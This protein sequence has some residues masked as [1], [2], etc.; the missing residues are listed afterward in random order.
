MIAMWMS[1]GQ[2]C[3]P[4]QGQGN[5]Q[6]AQ[7]E[8]GDR[9]EKLCSWLLDWGRPPVPIARNYNVYANNTTNDPSKATYYVVSII[10]CIFFE[11][12]RTTGDPIDMH[13]AIR[14]MRL[15]TDGNWMT[16]INQVLLGCFVLVSGAIGS[17]VSRRHTQTT[18]PQ[19]ATSGGQKKNDVK[20]ASRNIHYAKG[21]VDDDVQAPE[22]TA[23]N[24]GDDRTSR[25][26]NMLHRHYCR[27]SVR[28]LRFSQAV[29]P[30]SPVQKNKQAGLRDAPPLVVYCW[31]T[32]SEIFGP[33]R[34]V[35][36]SRIKSKLGWKSEQTD[37]KA[38]KPDH[39]TSIVQEG[40]DMAPL[41]PC[42]QNS[43]LW[44]A[45]ER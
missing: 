6:N 25:G 42:F 2:K 31:Q 9:C 33:T 41:Q 44:R 16:G 26:S 38:M 40:W 30:L 45:D 21:Q 28:K 8:S 35:M 36:C 3:A 14:N 19:R 7:H 10:F 1:L 15:N 32:H 12:R 27:I 39:T 4:S 22:S 37:S 11:D 5:H 18:G 34:S 24:D 17:G 29:E 23:N 20:E 13:I 43:H